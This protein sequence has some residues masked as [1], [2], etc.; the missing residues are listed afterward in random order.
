M[1]LT[2]VSGRNWL[3]RAG[4][5]VFGLAIVLDLGLLATGN[6][7]A[8]PGPLGPLMDR[9][10]VPWM[11]DV[12]LP[13]VPGGKESGAPAPPIEPSVGVDQPASS[14]PASE[15]I[16]TNTPTPTA[17][18]TVVPLA[19]ASPTQRAEPS[20]T[21]SATPTPMVA[22]PV[23]ISAPEIS[24]DAPV[25]HVGVTADGV[26]QTPRT[27]YEVGWYGPPPGAAGNAILTGHVDWLV[28]GRPVRGA[29]YF[30]YDLH[31]GDV[32]TVTAADGAVYRFRVIWKQSYDASSAPVEDIA[33]PTNV[34]SI[35]LIT[36]GGEFDRTLRE[37]ADR[38]VVRA[39][40][41]KEG[42]ANTTR[43]PTP[44]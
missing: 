1:R 31:P 3:Q 4:L 29:F 16:A 17:S 14:R 37:Y 18:A 30:L 40:L 39:I 43:Q 11:Q 5:G 19:T 25:I 24:L 44:S 34:P 21:P 38:W 33:G 15:A 10:L 12:L 36:C 7:G 2:T 8:L 42:G 27:E 28:S 13:L 6:P 20:P 22:D 9:H 35:T 23:K 32:I 26:M 41:V